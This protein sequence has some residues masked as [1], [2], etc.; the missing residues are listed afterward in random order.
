MLRSGL[1]R[2]L[3]AGPRAAA[4]HQ[5]QR[6]SSRELPILIC[7]SF[8]GFGSGNDDNSNGNKTHQEVC[9]ANWLIII[10]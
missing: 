8:Y 4:R 7:R 3:L 6:Q 2:G 9:S 1:V 5:S 10:D